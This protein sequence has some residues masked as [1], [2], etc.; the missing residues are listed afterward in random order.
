MGNNNSSGAGVKGISTGTPQ[1]ITWGSELATGLD[2]LKFGFYVSWSRFEILDTL[3]EAKEQ[4]KQVNEPV[5]ISFTPEGDLVFNCHPTG[6]KGGFGFHLSRADV[7][8]FFSRRKDRTTPNIWVDIGSVSCWRPGYKFVISEVERLIKTMGGTIVRNTVSEVHPCAD[9]IG[10]DIEELP[11]DK[12]DHW[13][14]RANRYN[15]YQDR[16][17]MSGITLDQTEG[18]LPKGSPNTI[19]IRETGIVFGSGSIM[20]RIYDKQLEIKRNPSKQSVFNSVW[21]IDEHRDTAVTRVEFQL[22][23]DVLKQM[24][25]NTLKDLEK[26]KVGLWRYCTEEWTR[27]SVKPVDRKNRHQDR[28]LI[29]PWWHEVQQINFG[30]DYHQVFRKKVEPSKNIEVLTDMMA[31]CALSLATILNRKPDALEEVI[32]FG[33]GSLEGRIRRMHREKA[34]NGKNLFE[35]K[36]ERRWAEIWPLGFVPDPV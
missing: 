18:E 36:M 32:A 2:R 4:A 16:T 24:G 27:L 6:R 28:S 5:P 14:T 15:C 20:L 3:G 7:N 31:G 29:H 11:I 10:L 19:L 25:I 12:Y 23:R 33:L 1:R 13:I 21:E 35:H 34:D 17:R 22:R 9:F 8:I 26:K 30:S